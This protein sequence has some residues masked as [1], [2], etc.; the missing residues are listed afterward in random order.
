MQIPKDYW[1][2]PKRY[3]YGATP[4]SW[5]GWAS[6]A[7]LVLF[8]LLPVRLGLFP[9]GHAQPDPW[10]VA[11]WIAYVAV[12]LFAYALFAKRL[13]KGEW[14]WRWGERD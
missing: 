7:A 6:I 2:R 9:L 4:S 12:V 8:L 10:R 1:F 14:R 5:K 13:T 3:G 11:V